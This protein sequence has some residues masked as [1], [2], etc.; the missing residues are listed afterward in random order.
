MTDNCDEINPS[1]EIYVCIKLS[2]VHN[3]SVKSWKTQSTLDEWRG[4]KS[5][6]IGPLQESDDYR[7]EAAVRSRTRTRKR[8]GKKN[9]TRMTRSRESSGTE[10][11]PVS[12]C[13]SF[14]KIS[15]KKL[16]R[17]QLWNERLP[18]Y[19]TLWSSN[20]NLEVPVDLFLKKKLLR[21]M[22]VPPARHN[23]TLT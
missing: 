17:W 8:K 2:T 3:T 13:H 11:Y 16:T 22:W 10:P 12:E 9:V 4:R 20:P 21:R 15:K 6:N 1:S 14:H 19:I 23:S 18:Q 5:L 7:H